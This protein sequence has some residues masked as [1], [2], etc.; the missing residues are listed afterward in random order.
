MRVGTTVAC[1]KQAVDGL[2]LAPT[3]LTQPLCR[4]PGWRGEH[5]LQSD[6]IEKFQH[7]AHRR[8]L[9]G[10]R[11][12]GQDDKAI[13]RRPF[14]CLPLPRR[15]GNCTVFLQRVQQLTHIKLIFIFRIRQLG[16][17]IRDKN[18]CLMHRL[19]INCIAATDVFTHQIPGVLQLCKCIV[20]QL[21][22]RLKAVLIL[23]QPAGRRKQLVFWNKGMP[24]GQ[25]EPERIQDSRL[26]PFRA[27]QRHAL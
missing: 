1:F 4:T 22:L 8:R 10:A 11:A 27:V 23:Q 6:S 26:Q 15:I 7:T 19:Q 20:Q 24:I 14:N 12:A 5:S 16:E 21:C 17:I 25:V 18:L 13:P 9:T 3:Q 2:R